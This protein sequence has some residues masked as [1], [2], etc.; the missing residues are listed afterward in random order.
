MILLIYLGTD[1][2]YLGCLAM[3]WAA[4]FLTEKYSMVGIVR[5]GFHHLYSRMVRMVLMMILFP[6]LSLGLCAWMTIFGFYLYLEE[7]QWRR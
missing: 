7:K 6:L 4:A 1:A 2:A 3:T 5:K